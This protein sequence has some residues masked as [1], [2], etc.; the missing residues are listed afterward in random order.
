M[1]PCC[2]RTLGAVTG[3]PGLHSRPAAMAKLMDSVLAPVLDHLGIENILAP[4]GG[5]FEST[6]KTDA[7]GSQVQS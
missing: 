6:C 3:G 1:T 4:Q 5:S 2:M 7:P